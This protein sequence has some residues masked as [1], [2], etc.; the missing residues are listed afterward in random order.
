[1]LLV[2]FKLLVY[3]TFYYLG[4]PKILPISYTISVT[5]QCNSKCRTCFI[6]N[7]KTDMLSSEEFSKVFASFGKSPYWVTISGGEPFIR[8]DLYEIVVSLVKTCNPSIVNIPTNGILTTKIISTIQKLCHEMPKTKFII[9]LSIDGTDDLH[10]RI[11]NVPGNY[12]K[13]LSTYK[14][15]RRLHCQNLSI[16]IHSVI[17][18]F[19]I[20]R[21]TQIADTLMGLNPDS[22]IT[23]IAEERQEMLNFGKGIV[24]DSLAY[25]SAIDFLLHRIKNKN[26][27]GI[28]KLTQALRIEYYSLVKKILRNNSRVINCYAGIA[29]CQIA[30]NG[31]V[32]FC[33]MKAK[34]VDNLKKSN[35][36]FKS[37]WFSNRARDMRRE[38]KKQ[39]CFCPMANASY[40]NMLL[41]SKTMMKVIYQ[42]FTI[43]Q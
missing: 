28:N 38:I 17:S 21:F 3:K 24:P 26:Y 36:N 10:D 30:P 39:K 25:R 9:N 18:S 8:K 6:Y 13:V 37:I 43:W 22:Y 19:N 12:Q 31:D 32:W 27:T 15:L 5:N 33:C 1:M 20:E 4:L 34:V 40:T 42:F 35:Y 14:G 29:S 41:S 23:E 11:R 7:K 16:G 2:L